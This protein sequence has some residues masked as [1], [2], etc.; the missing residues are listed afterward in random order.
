MSTRSTLEPGVVSVANLASW[1]YSGRLWGKLL[2]GSAANF[3]AVEGLS[4]NRMER[5]ADGSLR[6]VMEEC[7]F[8]KDPAS[9]ELLDAWTNPLNGLPCTAHHFRSRQD[10]TFSPDGKL[11]GVEPLEGVIAPPVV[12]GPTLWVSESLFGAI[13]V[14]GRKADQEPLSY[15]GPV[16]SMLSLAT[17]TC[18][19]DT[20]LADKPGFVPGTLHFQSSSPWYPWM[21]MGQAPGHNLLRTIRPQDREHR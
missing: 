18:E 1:W 9:G 3:F 11:V 14:G 5:R 7:G 20:I 13:P 21:R 19:T 12:S 2:N 15:S 4:F 17:F 10:L 6:Q 8:W 16:R